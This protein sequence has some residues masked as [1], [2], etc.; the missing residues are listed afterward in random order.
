MIC[1]SKLIL[2][3][4]SIKFNIQNAFSCVCVRRNQTCNHEYQFLTQK[5]TPIQFKREIHVD[6]RSSGLNAL[7]TCSCVKQCNQSN[8]IIQ[9]K[10]I[11]FSWC[12]LWLSKS[13]L[14]LIFLITSVFLFAYVLLC[15]IMV[16]ICLMDQ[17]HV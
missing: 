14:W 6:A 17:N 7:E 8:L 2:P 13:I 12:F 9:L 4:Q 10:P 11:T 16:L 5:R 15:C 3:C 1:Q